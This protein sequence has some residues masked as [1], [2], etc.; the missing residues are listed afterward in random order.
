MVLFV[1][2]GDSF[3]FNVVELLPVETVVRGHGEPLGDAL[4]QCRAVVIGPGPTDPERAAL[5]ELVHE[6]VGAEKPLLG[7]CLGHQ[8]IGLAFGAQ[9]VRSTP[10][11]GKVAS[12]TVADSRYLPAGRHEVMRYHSLSVTGVASPLRAVAALD[13]GTVMAV[14]HETL[15]ILGLQ[16]HPDS[17][18]TP[19][20]R[21]LVDAFLRA[22]LGE[23][24]R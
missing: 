19:G 8:A 14:E 4:A 2:N 3:S 5:V 17:Y 1:E 6:V 16:F 22:H 11:H 10:T 21:A 9:L 7:I 18:A 23:R 20:G 15:P 12:M 13:D 24:E